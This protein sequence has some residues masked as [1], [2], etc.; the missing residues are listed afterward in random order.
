V[1]KVTPLLLKHKT[2]AK[3]HQ[4]L[5]LRVADGSRTLYVSLGVRLHPRHW[6]DDAKRVR[7][8]HDHT[9]RINALVQRRLS[10]AEDE[11]LRL[12]TSREPVTAERIKAA[13]SPEKEN[14]LVDFLD[15]A[16]QR[17]KEVERRGLI[18]RV[19][20]ERATLTKLR[21]FAGS[22]LPFSRLTTQLVRDFETYLLTVKKNKPITV[23]ANMAVL[24]SHYGRAL[25]DGLVSRDDDPFFAFKPVRAGQATKGRLSMEEIKAIEALDLG[26]GGPSGSPLSRVRDLFLFA[27]YAAGVRLGDI[28][29]LQRENVTS[30]GEGLLRLAFTASKTGKRTAAL[31]PQPATRVLAPYLIS[32]DGEPKK[33]TDSLFDVLG[34]YDLSTPTKAHRAKQSRTTFINRQLGLLQKLSGISTHLSFHVARHSFADLARKGGMD[35]YAISKALKHSNLGITERYLAS[36]DSDALD[37]Q[38]G[39]LFPDPL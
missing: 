39:T 30:A 33:P 31:L 24:K 38:L 11:R 2:D 37:G 25:R 19:R 32:A 26:P 27:L 14:G 6:N 18:G 15:F 21:A 5:Y 22:P 8:G 29:N 3:G 9:D 36:F 16:E 10:E 12:L 7:K 13:L 28:V 1:A 23:H 4:P 17:L 34:G 35:V 20:T